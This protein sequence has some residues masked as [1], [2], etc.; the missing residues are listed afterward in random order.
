M[1]G[2]LQHFSMRHPVHVMHTRVLLQFGHIRLLYAFITHFDI[3]W[4]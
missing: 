3:D 1:R 4:L 2:Y